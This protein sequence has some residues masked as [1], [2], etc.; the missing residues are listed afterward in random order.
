MTKEQLIEELIKLVG[1]LANRDELFTA[2]ATCKLMELIHFM[3]DETD[4]ELDAIHVKT[5]LALIMYELQR[6]IKKSATES[7]L[8]E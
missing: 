1:Q 2:R 3:E 5:T 4:R 6:T 7:S 8:T